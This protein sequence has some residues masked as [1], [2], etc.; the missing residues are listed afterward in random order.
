MAAWYG[1]PSEDRESAIELLQQ[2]DPRQFVRKVIFP[3]ERIVPALLRISSLQPSAGPTAKSISCVSCDWWY[4]RKLA[5]S[6]EVSCWP[7][8]S[9]APAPAG[10]VRSSPAA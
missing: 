9:A 7:R 3:N 1:C 5:I 8:E 10:C 4:S 6:S 2:D